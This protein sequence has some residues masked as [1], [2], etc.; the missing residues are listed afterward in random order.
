[1]IQYRV[2]GQQEW[3]LV[4]NNILKE[5][6]NIIIRDLLPATSYDL[7]VSAQNQVGPTEAKYRFTT[8]DLNGKQVS[9]QQG[10]SLLGG[11][12]E[13][14]EDFSDYLDPDGSVRREIWSDSPYKNSLMMFRQLL[15]SPFAL[16]LSLC[17]FLALFMLLIFYR[18]Q[19]STNSS[20]SDTL[21]SSNKSNGSSSGS[22]HHHH[23]PY[24]GGGN[25]RHSSGEVNGATI[26]DSTEAPVSVANGSISESPRIN[27]QS[28]RLLNSASHYPV[29]VPSECGYYQA[30]Y[31]NATNTRQSGQQQQQQQLVDYGARSMETSNQEQSP[32]VP[33]YGQAANNYQ[34]AYASVQRSATMDATLDLVAPELQDQR[35]QQQCL[36]QMLMMGPQQQQQQQ[37]QHN[38]LSNLTDNQNSYMAAALTTLARNKNNPK[39]SQQNSIYNN[40][41]FHDQTT[42]PNINLT[43]NRQLLDY[44]RLQ[45]QQQQPN[46]GLYSG[47]ITTTADGNNNH[48]QQSNNLSM[49]T[50][51]NNNKQQNN[52][53]DEAY[54]M[55]TFKQPQ[56]QQIYV[57]NELGSLQQQPLTLIQNNNYCSSN[58]TA[59]TSGC[60]TA[61]S[62][63]SNLVGSGSDNDQSTT[64]TLLSS[65]QA[66]N[67]GHNNNNNNN[68]NTIDD[69]HNSDNILPF[70]D[71]SNN[72]EHLI[73]PK[74]NNFTSSQD[75][76][77]SNCNLE[78]A[79]RMTT[80]TCDKNSQYD[81]PFKFTKANNP[82]LIDATKQ[83]AD[84]KSETTCY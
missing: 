65:S 15:N 81:V 22:H 25:R 20:T 2:R 67:E 49:V 46:S 48:R 50:T 72:Q 58:S 34:G 79:S 37:P 45:Q 3:I 18:F 11:S 66:N 1:M 10:H 51:M 56:R 32:Y 31:C 76:D 39:L 19:G 7:F 5:Q 82:I 4:S 80:K 47:K 6:L 43:I 52:R 83:G 78:R 26:L 74:S 60:G 33:V 57:G 35:Q 17:L 13:N 59:S 54:P 28:H 29:S 84:L 61:T 55:S 73:M 14:S 38:E 68:N 8:L 64:T 69:F 27:Y 24:S 21:S 12:S 62:G 63:I 9:V 41:A 71:S 75:V 16:T 30:A 36:V 40:H 77:N 23:Q 44:Q 42:E 70:I 53:S